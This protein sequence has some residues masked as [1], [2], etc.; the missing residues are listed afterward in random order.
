MGT[1]IYLTEKWEQLPVREK[2]DLRF[3][4]EAGQLGYLR[5][6]VGMVKENTLLRELFPRRIWENKKGEPFDFIENQDNLELYARL[7]LMSVILNKELDKSLIKEQ[8]KLAD[9][10]IENLKKEYPHAEME[11]LE[12]GLHEPLMW[13]NS[14]FYFF[15]EGVKLQKEKGENPS[16]II[17]W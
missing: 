7:Y 1:D 14:L 4:I 17:D 16:I 9:A 8:L 11:G 15:S 13:L 6:S 2:E 12:G 5:A 3:S 10:T